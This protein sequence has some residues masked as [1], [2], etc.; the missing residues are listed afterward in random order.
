MKKLRSVGFLLVFL[1]G[2]DVQAQNDNLKNGRSYRII[3]PNYDFPISN[4]G[5]F[6]SENYDFG[7]E[8]G[9][10]RNLNH[11]LNLTVPFKIAKV[12]IPVNDTQFAP[13]NLLASLDATLQAKYFRPNNLLIPYVFAG[14]GAAYNSYD[15]GMNM[16]IP[17]GLGV[18]IRLDP[19]LYLNLQ[20]EY[21]I[22]LAERRS[23]LQHSFGI[24]VLIDDGTDKPEPIMPKDKD[25]DGITDDVDN[26]PNI[27]G[28]AALQGCPDQ[29]GDGIT[30]SEDACPKE[31]GSV[32]LNGCPDGDGDGIIDK[33]DRCPEAK[34]L[35]I[36][37]GCPDGDGDGIANIDDECPTAAGSPNLAGCPDSDDDGIAD[38]KDK[39]PKT[40]GPRSNQGCPEIEAKDMEVLTFATQAVEFETAKAVLLPISLTILDDIA[41]ILK[42]YPEHS[43]S[44]D[45]HTDSIGNRGPNQV[46]SEKRA[47]ACYD[48]LV[49]RGIRANRMS[50]IGY[51]ESRPIADNMYKAGRQKNRRVEFNIFIK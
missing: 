5:L 1:V 12:D 22:G 40:K 15:R 42:K 20:S 9:Y 46:L 43:L 38:P 28:V 10:W 7:A 29:D 19:Q 27:A 16:D 48:Y 39:C 25:G 21:R 13:K 51:G 4:E 32:D 41:K 8:I 45:G 31:S 23:N 17:L 26:C 35:A 2:S 49:A 18:N 30:D 34:G 37:N 3:F 50:Y 14:L 11:W 6:E 33:E 24:L 44:I 47:K 36:L